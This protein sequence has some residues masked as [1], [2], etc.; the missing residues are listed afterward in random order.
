MPVIPPLRQSEVSSARLA[1]EQR[2][3]VRNS[4]SGSV[5]RRGRSCRL[6][7]LRNEA[8]A[9]FLLQTAGGG[10]YARP[11]SA[12]RKRS[13]R[14][15]GSYVSK[16][17]AATIMGPY[18][19]GRN[20]HVPGQGTVGVIGRRRDGPAMGQAPDRHGHAVVAAISTRAISL[21]RAI[22]AASASRD[23]RGLGKQSAF[24]I[25]ASAMMTGERRDTG[26]N[27]V[28]QTLSGGSI[29]A[30]SSTV[31]PDT[32]KAARRQSAREIRNRARC[33]DL[34]RPLVCR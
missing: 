30:V 2:E 27:G 17:G 6:W 12:T 10:G 14:H 11:T 9:K 26:D 32:V 21:R 15:R 16:D 28:L 5:R 3:R 19:E 29:I 24:V 1:G 23:A 8:G 22:W 31:A 20:R 4:P 13:A 34:P 33:T 7:P 18:T 25:L